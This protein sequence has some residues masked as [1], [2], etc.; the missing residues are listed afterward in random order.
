MNGISRALVLGA[1]FSATLL[2]RLVQ[3][4]T[5]ADV[6]QALLDLH[7]DKVPN[8]CTRATEFLLK[9]R[10][11]LK[12]ELLDELYKTDW[13]GRDSI[14]QVLYATQ[15]FEPDKRFIHLAAKSLR[16]NK[17]WDDCKHA[18]EWFFE[19]REQLKDDLVEELHTADWQER[20]TIL[21]IL[22]ETK[23]FVPDQQFNRFLLDSITVHDRYADYLGGWQANFDWKFIDDHFSDFDDLLREQIRKTDSSPEAMFKLWA[24][25]WLAK[26][27][28]VFNEY[29]KL[30]S[31]SVQAIA[32]QNLKNDK[33]SHNA[34]HAVRLFFLLGDSA[35]P[36]LK[37]A[38]VSSDK[39]QA[40]LARAIMDAFDG[41]RQGFGFLVTRVDISEAAFGPEI[42]DPD[43]IR[44]AAQPYLR[45]DTY[46]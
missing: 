3:A 33:V 46:P 19:R 8:N 37:R 5:A 30:I 44:E 6:R 35:L 12:E 23:T 18:T 13:Q 25:A 15:S 28:G 38:A 10:E 21:S 29:S 9:Y 39:Q 1:V 20:N 41:Q 43:W 2:G 7:D 11:Q 4:Q 27:R 14:L 45:R 34:S 24:I 31:P 22:N 40:S 17:I 16:D 42:Q 32:S 36:T 26:K